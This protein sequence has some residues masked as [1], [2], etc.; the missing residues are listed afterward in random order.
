MN[1]LSL[2]S[3][4]EVDMRK[5]YTRVLTRHI[6]IARSEL[7]YMDKEYRHRP[8]LEANELTRGIRHLIHGIERFKREAKSLPLDYVA[9]NAAYYANKVSNPERES[10]Y[11]LT[12]INEIHA[13]HGYPQLTF[14]PLIGREHG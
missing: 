2:F 13:K 5:F 12:R 4:Y 10:K 6:Q 8:P 14:I 7:A 11:W 3:E 1:Q 9:L